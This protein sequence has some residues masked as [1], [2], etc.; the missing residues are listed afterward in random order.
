MNGLARYLELI[1][2]PTFEDFKRSPGSVR[3][4]YLACLVTYHAIDRVTYPAKPGNLLDKWRKQSI[5][6]MLVEE[7]ALHL[8]HVKSDSA[9][10]PL[11]PDTLRVTHPLGLDG[12]GESLETRNLFFVVRDAIKFLHQQ[13]MIPVKRSAPS[14][15]KSRR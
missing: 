11:P 14:T 1:V 8:K 15:S 4:A 5:E 12:D 7:V 10:R 9:K 2:E 6:F 3:H 13:A